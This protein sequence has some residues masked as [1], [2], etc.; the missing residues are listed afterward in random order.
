MKRWIIMISLIFITILSAC[1]SNDISP[2]DQFEMY[3][4]EWSEEEF[5]NM[6]EMLASD[7]KQQYASEDFVDRYQKIYQDL[8][9]SELT[10]EFE[11]LTDKA[12]RKAEK[13]GSAT[14]PFT[15]ELQSIAGPISFNYEATLVEEEVDDDEA[16]FISW[17]SG[18][19]FPELKDGGNIAIQTT[20]PSR[21]EILDRN[22]MPLALNDTVRE[23]GIVPGEL[24]DNPDE[25]KERVA[26][27]LNLSVEEIDNK[28]NAGWVEPDLFV[29]L[30]T[31]LPSN[32]QLLE[33]LGMIEGV[34]GNEVTGRVYPLGEITAHLTGYVGQIT[35]EEFEEADPG[36][37]TANDVIG[38][39]GLESLFEEQLRGEAGAK[40]YIRKEDEDDIILA[41]KE[42][43]NGENIQLTID[44]NIQEKIYESY[45]GDAGTAAAINPKTGETLALISSPGYDPNELLYSTDANKWSRLEDDP[46]TPLINRFNATYAPGSVIKPVT[47]AVGLSNGTIK[48]DEGLNINGLTWSNGEGWGDYKVRRVSEG[49][50]PVDLADAMIR[51]DNIYFA[52]QAVDMG[53]EAY[54]EGLKQFG[55][56]EE[57][58]YAYPVTISTISSDGKL[59]NEVLLANTSYG[60]GEIQFSSLH[61]ALTYT[62]FLNEG[63]LLKPTLLLEEESGQIWRENI[64]SEEQA[65]LMQEI[66]RDV[67]TDGTAK[68]ARE[69][70]FPISGKTG[71]AELKLSSDSSGAEN[72]WF[73]GYP[74]DDQD[75]LIA[76]MVENTESKGG[77]SYT[78]D[79]VT[80][81]LMEIKK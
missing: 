69:A 67:V 50:G 49:S 1:T 66:L 7:S 9:V 18:Y 21:G 60:Q 51:S 44:V 46:K 28:L 12:L 15:V 58:P 65:E 13:E 64:I 55:L 26:D 5:A 43:K 59:D 35:A 70:D 17:D 36:K 57:L 41:E 54:I 63:H 81:A 24:G 10:V 20:Q 62:P 33:Q 52:M 79:K 80:N 4:N 22:K 37:Y 31:V 77:S 8:G 74:T 48:P 2:N 29:P 39:R 76:M 42:V 3:V 38:K 16:W 71:T 25:N 32:T 45:N 47:A 27:L 19:I 14:I 61:M 53:S 34:K 40:I 73:V 23:I 78:V 56:G 30:T 72:G 75:I 68:N 11:P 6:Y